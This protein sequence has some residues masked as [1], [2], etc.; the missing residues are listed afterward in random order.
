MQVDDLVRYQARVAAGG[1]P[2]D[3]WIYYYYAF[4]VKPSI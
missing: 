2:E 3:G 4:S 1:N